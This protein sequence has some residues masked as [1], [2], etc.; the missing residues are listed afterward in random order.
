MAQ[1]ASVQRRRDQREVS[2]DPVQRV[3]QTQPMGISGRIKERAPVP[4]LETTTSNQIGHGL[5]AYA[6]CHT[7]GGLRRY[8]RCSWPSRRSPVA[9]STRD[10]CKSMRGKES[11]ITCELP[12]TCGRDFERA[13]GGGGG[14]HNRNEASLQDAQQAAADKKRRAAR[15]PILAGRNNT[16]QNHLCRYPTVRA[17][18]LGDQLGRELRTEE[19]ESHNGVSKVVV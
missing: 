17:H 5:P 15:E 9:R 13:N 12:L 19:R 8:P 10:A 3:S 7:R 6:G 2:R 11:P 18:P 1:Q 14:P 16:P 4:R